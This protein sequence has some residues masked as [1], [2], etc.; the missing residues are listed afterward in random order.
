MK[1][2]NSLFFMFYHISAYYKR[3][4]FKEWRELRE[5]KKLNRQMDRELEKR[6]KIFAIGRE[7]EKK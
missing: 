2:L 1:F 6:H 7:G 5:M 4:T 3:M